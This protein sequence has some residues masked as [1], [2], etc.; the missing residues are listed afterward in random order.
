[1]SGGKSIIELV[2]AGG[3]ADMDHIRSLFRE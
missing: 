3:P 1:M 2:E